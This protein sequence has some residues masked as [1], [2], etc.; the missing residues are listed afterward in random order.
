MDNTSF[1]HPKAGD[2]QPAFFKIPLQKLSAGTEHL[3]TEAKIILFRSPLFSGG[4]ATTII[5]KVEIKDFDPIL[6]LVVL[7]R[8]I[9]VFKQGDRAVGQ[10]GAKII[11]APGTDDHIKRL[12][13]FFDVGILHLHDSSIVACY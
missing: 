1:I 6:L 10:S 4:K 8:Q 11:S 5:M 3:S 12:V 9:D 2:P 13:S 7:E